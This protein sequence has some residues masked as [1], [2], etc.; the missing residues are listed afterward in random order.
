MTMR[1]GQNI[2]A[3][4]SPVRF[5]TGRADALPLRAE[6]RLLSIV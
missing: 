4:L 1:A 5:L 6:L 3:A 2:T